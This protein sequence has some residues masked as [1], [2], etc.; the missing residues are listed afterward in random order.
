MACECPVCYSANASC[1]LV[2]GHGFCN[3]CVKTWYFKSEEPSCPMCRR[4]MYFKGMWKLTDEWIQERIDQKNQ[5]M[6]GEAFEDIF[7]EES[8]SESETGSETDS[9]ASEES[10]ET[11]SSDSSDYKEFYSQ[12]MLAEIVRLQKDYKKAMELGLDFEWYMY[13]MD[14]FDIVY[15][16]R[17][18][19]F[20]D[21]FP[22]EKNM[23]VS[24]YPH[25][26]QNKRSGK[27]VPSK[28][29]TSY[30]VVFQVFV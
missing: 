4:K 26:L 30:T 10:W 3:A 15:E 9:D 18:E 24:K 23:F 11:C 1:K 16:P 29:D 20:D 27:R 17:V 7:D 2:C 5:T 8:D 19:V 14:Y 13:N 22:H 6:F 28:S 25:T 21:I 12:F